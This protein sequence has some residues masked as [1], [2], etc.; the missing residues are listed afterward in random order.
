MYR[1]NSVCRY[2]ES[3]HAMC[4][5]ECYGYQKEVEELAQLKETIKKNKHREYDIISRKSD[6][7]TKAIK[8][9]NK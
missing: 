2:C 8:Q 1:R 3:R 5:S 7:I 9:K 4:H 6:G